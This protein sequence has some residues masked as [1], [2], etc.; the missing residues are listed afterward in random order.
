MAAESGDMARVQRAVADQNVNINCLDHLGR[1]ALELALMGGHTA[2]VEYLLPRSNLQ[3]I[4]DT[5]MYAIEKDNVKMCEL[6]L[7]HPLYR[8]IFFLSLI[9]SKIGPL[10]LLV[11]LLSVHNE[12]KSQ[13][14]FR[15]SV[16]NYSRPVF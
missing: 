3:C 2:I 8:C 12:S 16:R 15:N 1:S 4:E 5:L 7:E 9:S 11:T 10:L 6:I 13:L 14:P